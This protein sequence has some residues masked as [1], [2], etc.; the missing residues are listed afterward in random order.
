M[1]TCTSPPNLLY[2]QYLR[3]NTDQLHDD[4][5]LSVATTRQAAKPPPQQPHFRWDVQ[6]TGKPMFP[7]FHYISQ[8]LVEHGLHVALIISDQSP[9]VIPVW[10]LS[11]R[12][13]IIFTR[14]VRTACAKYNVTPSWMTAVRSISSKRDLPRVFEAYQPD[15]YI[16]RRSLLQQEIVFMADG[17]TLL[18]IDHIYTLKQLLCTL[19]KKDWVSCSRQ[20]CLASCIHLLHRINTIHV[21]IRFSKGYIARVYH[22]IPLQEKALDAVMAEHDAIFCTSSDY[23]EFYDDKHQER[24]VE[25]VAELQDTRRP[26]TQPSD[27]L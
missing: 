11:H 4:H 25:E 27:D 22:D 8:Q 14:I 2:H 1:R 18:S 5:V 6:A 19:S 20:V 24:S 21:G 10:Q 15:D 17:L 26:D 9:F 7:A 13:Q 3:G 12:S 23:S 16:V